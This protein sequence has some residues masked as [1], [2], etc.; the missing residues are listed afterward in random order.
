VH[1]EA[2]DQHHA[3]ESFPKANTV[4]QERAAKLA[5]DL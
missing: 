4:A 1:D 3:D 5:G 2:L